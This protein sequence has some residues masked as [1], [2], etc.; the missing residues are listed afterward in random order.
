MSGRVLI[1]TGG[2]LTGK[3]GSFLLAARKWWEQWRSADAAWLD[4]KVKLV[5][6]EPL[7]AARLETLALPFRSR[8]VRNTVR[9]ALRH[10]ENLEPP[11]LTEVV[12]ATLAHR[13]GLAYETMELDEL[14]SDPRGVERR[15]AR[16][17]CVFLSSTYLHDL[18]EVEP[19]LQ[20]LKRSHNR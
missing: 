1:V 14:F 2:L 13:A 10:Q 9:E 3:E 15:L 18:S 12:L 8:K 16:T 4:F 7:L 6:A 17:D 5:M 20:R 11:S 19:L